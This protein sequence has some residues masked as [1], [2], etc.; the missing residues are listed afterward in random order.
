MDVKDAAEFSSGGFTS[1][2]GKNAG[3]QLFTSPAGKND[4]KKKRKLSNKKSQAEYVMTPAN[5]DLKVKFTAVKEEAQL[6]EKLSAWLAK[7]KACRMCCCSS[8]CSLVEHG[9]FTTQAQMTVQQVSYQSM[10][11]RSWL[12]EEQYDEDVSVEH[13]HKDYFL[14]LICA[15]NTDL[16]EETNDATED[17]VLSS[18]PGFDFE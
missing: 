1:S 15:V 16:G 8:H 11:D 13:M 12:D 14:S 17:A 2:A 7:K 6:G 18:C 4:V 9:P 3:G 10:L 5:G